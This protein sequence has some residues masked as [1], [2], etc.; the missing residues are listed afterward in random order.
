MAEVITDAQLIN[1]FASKIMEEPEQKVVTRA[2]SDSSVKLPGGFIKG[3]D[4]VTTAE[5]KELNGAD[6]EAIARAGSTGKALQVLLQKGDRKST[7]L[8]SSHE[9]ISRMP[10]SA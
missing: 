3:T 8:N 5:V 10:S 7:R 2:P 6:E 9:W 1:N 4:L